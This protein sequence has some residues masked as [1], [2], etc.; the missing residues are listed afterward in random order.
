MKIA[1]IGAGNVATHLGRALVATGHEVVAVYSRT[2]TSAE[3]LATDIRVPLA[4]DSIAELTA[5]AGSDPLYI[6]SVKDDAVK[7]VGEALAEAVP[8]AFVVHTAGSLP[9]DL[10]PSHRRGVLYPMQTFSRERAV[11]FSVIPLFIEAST[12]DNLQQLHALAGSLSTSVYEMPSAERAYLH[13]AAV[14]SCNFA[15]HLS[16]LAAELLQRHGIPFSVMLP[17]LDETTRKLHFLS[18]QAAQT[19]PAMRGDRTVM[20]AQHA[21][22]HREDDGNMSDIYQLLSESISKHHGH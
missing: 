3:R 7:A 19:G 4:T 14:F 11:D 10:L 21:L 17:L 6:I 1:L 2:R 9:M 20:A 16:T 12:T 5:A 15:N 18:P 22:L 13:I 8:E